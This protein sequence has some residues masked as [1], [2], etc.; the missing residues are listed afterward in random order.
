MKIYLLSP[1]ALVVEVQRGGAYND[2]DDKQDGDDNGGRW[3]G[4]RRPG[5]VAADVAITAGEVLLADAGRLAAVVGLV[6][7]AAVAAAANQWLSLH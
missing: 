4:A 7:G 6:A 1:L 5:L 3:R 2:H